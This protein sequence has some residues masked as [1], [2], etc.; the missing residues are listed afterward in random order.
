MYAFYTPTPLG[1]IM[2]KFGG[3]WCDLL[4]LNA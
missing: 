3:V 2:Q 4:G 1:V